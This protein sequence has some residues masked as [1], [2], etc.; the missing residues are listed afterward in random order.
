MRRIRRNTEYDKIRQ[1]KDISFMLTE[2][3]QLP[4]KIGFTYNNN[5]EQQA[6]CDVYMYKI[7]ISLIVNIVTVWRLTLNLYFGFKL[8]LS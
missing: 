5:N 8:V 3:A 6:S 2:E 4:F 1:K 7:E